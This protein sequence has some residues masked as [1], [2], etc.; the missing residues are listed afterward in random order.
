MDILKGNLTRNGETTKERRTYFS[1]SGECKVMKVIKEVQQNG[2]K[3]NDY[4]QCHGY[5]FRRLEK[6]QELKFTE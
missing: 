6:L 2:L 5:C 1:I 3:H 4:Q